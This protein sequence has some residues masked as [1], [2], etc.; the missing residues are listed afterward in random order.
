[1]PSGFGASFAGV[2]P[3]PQPMSLVSSPVLQ[4]AHEPTATSPFD[5]YDLLASI[6]NKH[7][8]SGMIALSV[9]TVLYDH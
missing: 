2:P 3:S 8:S 5:Y 4:A 7:Y 1:M 6:R 9:F